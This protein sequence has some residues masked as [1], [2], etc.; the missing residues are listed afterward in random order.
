MQHNTGLQVE[1][2]FILVGEDTNDPTR[3]NMTVY[4]LKKKDD[5][6]QRKVVV[7]EISHNIFVASTQFETPFAYSSSSWVRNSDCD[8]DVSKFKYEQ[9]HFNEDKPQDVD[10][11]IQTV[12]APY[13]YLLK[14]K[15]NRPYLRFEVPGW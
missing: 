9:T 3:P 2:E 11:I 4:P 6:R 13:L 8:K 5:F 12:D 10:A 14:A 7:H 1:D 15:E